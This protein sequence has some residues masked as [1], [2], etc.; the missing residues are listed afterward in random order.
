VGKSFKL[1]TP[2]T[3]VSSCH[4]LD[5]AIWTFQ[6][7]KVT[8]SPTAWAAPLKLLEPTHSLAASFY[9][10]ISSL[11]VITFRWPVKLI[12]Q[13]LVLA[14]P[15]MVVSMILWLLKVPLAL[16]TSTLS[17]SSSLQVMTI[18]SDAAIPKPTA[19]VVSRK[20][21]VLVSFLAII[22]DLA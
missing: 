17:I 14:H 2:R 16:D 6:I 22:V 18:V 5:L 15:M 20:M 11:L 10:L 9:P 13:R 8:L 12:L 4:Q 3:S 7:T 1:S 21:D 19:T